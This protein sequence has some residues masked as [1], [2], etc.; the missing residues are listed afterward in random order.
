MEEFLHIEHRI[1]F[2]EIIDR[3]GQFMGYDGQGFALAMFMLQASE[4]F[5]P[6][7]IVPQ[8]QDSRLREGPLERG[9]PNLRARG[10]GAFAR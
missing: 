5:L 10:P 1:P 6:H 8:K 3:S 7:W 4:L 2:E 9:I